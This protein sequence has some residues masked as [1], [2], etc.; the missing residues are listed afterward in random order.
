MPSFANTIRPLRF[1]IAWGKSS[2]FLPL[3]VPSLSRLGFFVPFLSLVLHIFAIV[4]KDII[5]MQKKSLIPRSVCCYLVAALCAFSVLSCTTSRTA[6][7]TVTHS[8]G[9]SL[10]ALSAQ[11]AAVSQQL[12][13]YDSIFAQMQ[14]RITAQQSTQEQSTERIQ[15]SVTTY[16][17]SLGRE[18]RQENR[19]IDRNL[20]RQTELRY[21]QQISSLQQ[22]LS[23]ETA[24]TD[25]LSEALY[26]LQQVNWLDSLNQQSYKEPAPSRI[27]SWWDGLV[28]HLG[29]IALFGILGVLI[30]LV[31][32]YFLCK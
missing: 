17:D 10:R 2:L 22:Q 12:S 6:T 9:D 29:Y 1:S 28:L 16:L 32:R 30:F 19:T 23:Q 13:C 26:M 8:E 11:Y 27:Q 5:A 7:S 15:E 24:R 3:T 20:S 31:A 14:A 21:E 4:I 25:S 18:V